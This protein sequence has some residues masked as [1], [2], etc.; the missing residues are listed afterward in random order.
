MFMSN[1][2]AGH[3]IVRLSPIT[4]GTKLVFKN[5]V[6]GVLPP[7]MKEGMTEGW[8]DMLTRIKRDAEK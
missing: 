3:L 4:G 8:N 5:D 1:P 6:F 2:V 7:E